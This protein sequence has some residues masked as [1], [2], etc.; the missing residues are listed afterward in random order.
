MTARG[1]L[2]RA[3]AT[4]SA[5]A[6]DPNSSAT[7]IDTT[8]SGSPPPH[9]ASSATL[10]SRA[11]PLRRSMSRTSAGHHSDSSHT[12]S[13]SAASNTY[14]PTPSIPLAS[15]VHTSTPSSRAPGNIRCGAS[16]MPGFASSSSVATWSSASHSACAR[17]PA[18][19]GANSCADLHHPRAPPT[20]GLET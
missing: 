15:V 1:A 2:P 4:A 11:S 3:V 13:A 19:S 5:T 10:S 18:R 16:G 17:P 6:H 14:P 9:R 7:G 8:G 12:A 20:A